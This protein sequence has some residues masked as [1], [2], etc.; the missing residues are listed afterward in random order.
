MRRLAL[1]LALLAACAAAGWSEE[2]LSPFES[3]APL[4]TR[5]KI[6][7]LVFARL[8]RLG[9]QPAR[10]CS[11]AVFLRRA[12]LDV[13]GTLPTALEARTFLLDPDPGKRQALVERLLEREEFADYRALKWCDLLRVKSE[14]PIN[15]WPNG[16]QAYHHWIRDSIRRNVPYDRFARELLTA[17]GSNFR[18]PPVN[19]YRAVQSRE[20]QALAQAVALAFMG[21]RPAAWPKERWEGM[22]G[23]FAQVGYKYTKEWKE[24]ILFFDPGKPAAKAIF[25]DGKPAR[26][27]PGQDPR[28]AFADWLITPEN[29]WFTRNIANRVW[30]WLL[31]RGIIHEA[32]DIRPDNPPGHPELLALLERD[33]ITARYDLKRLFRLILN[34]QTYQLSSVPRTPGPEAQAAFASYLPRRLEAEALIDALCQITGTS[35]RYSSP[36]PEPFTYVPEE[37]RSIALADASISSPFLETFGRPPRDTGLESERNNLPSAEQR[38]YLL[39]S[40]HLRG[41][42]E[43]LAGVLRRPAARGGFPAAQRGDP[44]QDL[45]ELYLMIL[46]RFP[47]DEEAR[48]VLDYVQSAGQGAGVDVVWAL[49]NSSE[50]QYRH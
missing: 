18:V 7:S 9:V 14:F 12:Y 5:N 33:L 30:S 38:L 46:S 21:V 35:E 19:F 47:T 13:T 28:A 17:S 23:F 36:I 20:P 11:D 43:G 1:A 8:R 2:A 31:G 10:P 49:I 15:L 16:V 50:F 40:S 27:A 6:D 48:S 26:P 39:N 25:P 41:K 22:G 34:S 45:N 37:N 32:D 42:I 24:E 44:R 29:P 3:A 4:E